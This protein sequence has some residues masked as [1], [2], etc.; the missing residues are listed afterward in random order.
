MDL[1]V[2]GKRLRRKR[3]ELIQHYKLD[4]LSDEHIIRIAQKEMAADK[5]LR[6]AKE[7]V[8]QRLTGSQSPIFGASDGSPADPAHQRDEPR[9]DAQTDYR[10]TGPLKSNTSSTRRP[11]TRSS[12]GFGDPDEAKQALRDFAGE[13]RTT[14]AA[15]CRPAVIG[16]LRPR[17]VTRLLLAGT[18]VLRF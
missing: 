5:R 8:H 16:H 1:L 4:G 11:W 17:P 12:S 14:R 13:S 3:S 7:A 9:P 2:N 6:K 18:L 10:P 15:K